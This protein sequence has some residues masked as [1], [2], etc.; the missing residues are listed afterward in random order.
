[1]KCKRCGVGIG[2]TSGH[3]CADIEYGISG[4]A[5]ITQTFENQITELN[6]VIVKL[7]MIIAHDLIENDELGAEFV[8]VQALKEEI[9][10]LREAVD[11]SISDLSQ[12]RGFAQS[13]SAAARSETQFAREK[14]IERDEARAEAE[15]LRDIFPEMLDENQF[16][17]PVEEIRPLIDLAINKP[18][19]WKNS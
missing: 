11:K 17:K 4:D 7:K 13:Q 10:S 9:H 3:L 5:S 1:M 12:A 19:P 14:R 18:L 16:V 15:R 2:F 6:K 8:Y